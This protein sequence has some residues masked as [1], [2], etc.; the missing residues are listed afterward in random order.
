MSDRDLK[1][2]KRYVVQFCLQ[3]GESNPET[4]KMMKEAYKKNFWVNWQ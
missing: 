3:L 4:I 2:E 1:N